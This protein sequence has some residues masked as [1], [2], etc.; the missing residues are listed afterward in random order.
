MIGLIRMV[1]VKQ[2]IGLSVFKKT[3]AQLLCKIGNGR[4]LWNIILCFDY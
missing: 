1:H 4:I 2:L 3:K